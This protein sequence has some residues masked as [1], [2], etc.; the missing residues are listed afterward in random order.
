MS[1][2]NDDDIVVASTGFIARE[3][4]K[5]DRPLNFYVMGAMGSALGIGIG[6]AM[7]V[8]QRVLVINGDG[9]VLMSLGAMVT[10]K[11]KYLPNLL[12]FILDNGC[13]ESTGGQPTASQ[14][15]DFRKICRNTFVY[16]LDKDKTIP[17]R[18]TLSGKQITDRFKNALLRIQ[19]QQE[20]LK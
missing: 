8:G 17:P 4:F 1:Q 15:I 19:E 11:V 13:H 14:F 18:I 12:H 10:S 3:V 20:A 2:V 6:L 5:Y 7:N 16:K 9:S